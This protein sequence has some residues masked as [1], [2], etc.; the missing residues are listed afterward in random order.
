MVRGRKIKTLYIPG[1][2]D[3]TTEER[4]SAPKRTK[5]FSIIGGLVL[6]GNVIV[7]CLFFPKESSTGSKLTELLLSLYAFNLSA[8]MALFFFAKFKTTDFE[9]SRDKK[10]E[11][12]VI[13]VSILFFLLSFGF[14]VVGGV[15]YYL[16]LQ[17][18]GLTP[19]EERL[20]NYK[21][22]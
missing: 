18:R 17:K 9:F 19:P 14:M 12:L 1:F 5:V 3:Y 16:K 4:S 21:F 20:E 7:M 11:Y 22:L 13:L 8:A 15:F 10:G 6:V 2:Q